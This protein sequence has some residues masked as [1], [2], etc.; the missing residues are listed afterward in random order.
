MEE[1]LYLLVAG[2]LAGLLAGLL[3][4]GGGI[5]VVPVLLYLLPKFGVAP[6]WVAHVSVGTSLATIVF[7]GASSVWCH[8]ALGAVRWPMV[9]SLVPGLIF[10]A[11]AGAWLT[12]WV[13]G[14]YLKRIIG[15]VIL[16]VSLKMLLN[17]K[18]PA[19]WALP[20]L[21][22][23]FFITAAIG[24]L[25][26][27][28]GVGGGS[29]MVP[30]LTACRVPMHSAVAVSAAC[31]LPIAFFG[32]LGYVVSGLALSDLPASSIG[33]VFWPAALVIVVPSMIFA[34]FGAKLTHKIPV[35]LLKTLFGILLV[36]VGL[37][38]LF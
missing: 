23:R 33:Y 16:L 38:L 24:A 11:G 13:P 34:Q 20:K 22:P 15:L 2:A 31:G 10:G 9:Y 17:L 18:P 37:R 14:E 26:A 35:G 19:H 27:L 7:T 8:H 1:W 5:V 28:C 36:I 25:S 29:F 32:M 30:F 21:I 4:V 3:G 6:Q 12:A